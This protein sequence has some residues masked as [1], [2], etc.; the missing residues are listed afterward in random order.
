MSLPDH[1]KHTTEGVPL[2]PMERFSARRMTRKE[3]VVK[4]KIDT[5]HVS[6][7]DD[8]AVLYVGR[9]AVSIFNTLDL[10]DA[11]CDGLTFKQRLIQT[12]KGSCLLLARWKPERHMRRSAP[13][14]S[15]KWFVEKELFPPDAEQLFS[16]LEKRIEEAN[17]EEGAG[18]EA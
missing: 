10:P 5:Y 3:N 8:T 1:A 15:Q 4:Q 12:K 14:Q 6:D 13:P 17:Q 2:E 7:V 16:R 9:R 11:N 18:D